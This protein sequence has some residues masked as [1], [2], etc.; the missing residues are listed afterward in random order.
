MNSAGSPNVLIEVRELARE[1]RVGPSTVRALDG[2][3]I[4]VAE[5]EF[6][7]VLGVSGSGKSTLLHLVGGLGLGRA[8][9]WLIQIAINAY[10]CG[11]GVEDHL[12]VFEFPLWLSAATVLF[13]MTVAVI[14]GVY[15]AVRAARVDPIQA[16]RAK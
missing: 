8:V 7:A 4:D 13:S 6:L 1:Y 12:A 5:G 10:A 11:Q 3:D 16:L 2:L 15:P 9:S 14:A